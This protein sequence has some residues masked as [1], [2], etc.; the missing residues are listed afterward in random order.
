M[1]FRRAAAALFTCACV[2]ATPRAQQPSPAQDPEPTFRLRT[3]AVL[4]DVVVRGDGRRPVTGLTADD[5]E[6]REDGV[7][8]Y[9]TSF[10]A[11]ESQAVRVMTAGEIDAPPPGARVRPDDSIGD[12][13][14]VAI[15]FDRLTPES[16][17]LAHRAARQ[18][19]GNGPEAPGVIGV[20]GIGMSLQP[21]ANFTRDYRR[22]RQ[23]VDVL[24]QNQALPFGQDQAAILDLQAGGTGVGGGAVPPPLGT[25]RPGTI[26]DLQAMQ[27]RMMLGF[28]MAERDFRSNITQD[29]LLAVIGTMADVPGRKSLVLLSEGLDQGPSLRGRLQDVINAANRANVAIYTIDAAGL[30]TVSP[31]EEP[32]NRLLAMASGNSVGSLAGVER[33]EAL[34]MSTPAAS[35][36]RLARDTGGAYLESTNDLARVFTRVSE[37]MAN[38]YVLTYV[39][40][41]PTYDRKYRRIKV[42]VRRPGVTVSARHGYYAVAPT[43]GLVTHAWEAPAVSALEASRLP[44]AFPVQ[45]ERLVFP[46]ADSDVSIVPLLVQADARHFRYEQEGDRYRAEAVFLLRIRDINGQVLAKAS[47]QYVLEG[48][49]ADMPASQAQVMLF[50]RQVSLPPGTYVVE[51]VVQ[52]MQAER[53]S[54]RVGSL[55]VPRPMPGLPR[56]GSVFVV[57]HAQR[58]AMTGTQRRSP[59]LHDGVL[60]FPQVGQT[61]SRARAADLTFAFSVV[62]M[63]APVSGVDVEVARGSQVVGAAQL[64]LGPPGEG[65]RIQQIASLPVA[66]LAPG[67]YDLRVRVPVAGHVL[68]RATR[69]TVTP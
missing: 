7:V 39:S 20:F 57:Q 5:F 32:R 26:G 12:A 27:L 23:A 63:G 16:R 17:W 13:G 37:D 42:K 52:D 29:A 48:A 66:E 55:D 35:L 53:A 61:V 4:V 49:L 25:T 9:V 33:F 43:R 41:N 14:V 28:E 51:A 36:G 58:G 8:Q 67:T 11:R 59:L 18:F 50:H 31:L 6:I 2:A 69:F 60:L 40:S 3:D 54:V 19:I 1:T 47:D 21:V 45:L 46:T 56:L 64:A 34:L 24:G 68:S 44:N 22:I 10:T 65:G 30:R 62:P 15:V 38:H